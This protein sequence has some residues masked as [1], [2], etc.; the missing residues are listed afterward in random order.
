MKHVT[1]GVDKN[2]GG[3]FYFQ[4]SLQHMLMDRHVKTGGVVRLAHGAK[5]MGHSL[6]ITM[7]TAWAYLGASGN[8]VPGGLGPFDFCLRGHN[9]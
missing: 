5:T 2:R 8:R 1:H 3:S 4:R 7:L 6:R 9:L